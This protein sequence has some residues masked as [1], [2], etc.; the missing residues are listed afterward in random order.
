MQQSR[1]AHQ[2][3]RALEGMTPTRADRGGMK[4]ALVS[5][6]IESVPP[7]LYGGTERIVSI[8]ADEL[9]RQGHDVTLFASGDSVT[10]A[11]LVPCCERALRLTPNVRDIVPHHL[12][13]L[14]EVRR[15][16]DDFDIIHFHNDLLHFPLIPTLN[17][18]TVTTLHGRLDIPDLKPFYAR[19]CDAPLVA[20]SNSQR[21]FLPQGNFV[22][23]IYHGLRKDTLSFTPV[24]KGGYFAFLGRISPEKRP[25]R[26][27]EIAAR[28]GVP[29][30]I[31]AKVD[32]ADQEYWEEVIRPMVANN[33]N[34]EYIGEINERQKSEF[35]GNALALLFPIDWPEPFGI[36]MIE[37]MACGTPVLAFRCGSVPE[38]ID[39]GVTGYIVDTIDEAVAVVGDLL[40]LD[41]MAVRRRFEER[42]T[43]ER[44]TRAYVE[45]YR[46]LISLSEE[47]VL[48]Q[49]STLMRRAS[50]EQISLSPRGT[51]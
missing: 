25:D 4:I 47:P 15:Q 34:V 30:K 36:V 32:R 11:R 31:A 42:F 19:F 12:M 23:T 44:M 35:L 48:I 49:D 45:T 8:L 16:A 37:A 20:I 14:D 1:I 28:T 39:H 21:S 17:R 26:A 46:R 27:I 6:L 29:L 38:V 50:R 24:P 3:W 41:R 18:P 10:A 33:P 43:A 9:V 5:P 13:M 22:A 51:S 2:A 40:R 7:V